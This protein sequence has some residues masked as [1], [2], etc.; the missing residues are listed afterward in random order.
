MAPPPQRRAL[1]AL[2][3]VLALMLAG[4][5]TAAADAARHEARL[6]VIAFAAGALALWLG[7]L[8]VRALRKSPP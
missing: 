4:V 1:G 2:F 7:L 8:A 6:A 5:A 3:L